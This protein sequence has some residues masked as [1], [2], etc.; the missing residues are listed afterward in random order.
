LSE[1]E[2][3]LECAYQFKYVDRSDYERILSDI[4]HVRLLL[5]LRI[6]KL[7]HRQVQLVN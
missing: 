3:Y 6:D 1:T 2:F 5:N 4:N 7:Q